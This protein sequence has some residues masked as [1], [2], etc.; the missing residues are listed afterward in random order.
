MTGARM[1]EAWE[2]EYTEYVTARLP[3]L[4]RL[5]YQLSGDA[6]RADDLVQESIT[7]L[8]IHWAR[9]RAADHL[10]AYVRSIVVRTFLDERRRIWSRVRLFGTP[11]E[12]PI[13]ASAG[14]AGVDDRELVRTALARLPHRQRAVLVL[15]YLCDLPVDEV[16]T[17]L[18]CSPGTVKSQAHHALASL[19]RML[20]EGPEPEP[21][22]LVGGLGAGRER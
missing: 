1:E 2:T 17:A 4:R 15:R 22:A 8:Y 21:A 11:P 9:A 6:H 3:H 5:A 7:K 12:S 14:S 13:P 10:D 16:A 20:G 18:R 19:R